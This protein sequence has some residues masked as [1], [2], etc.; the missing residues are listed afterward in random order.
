MACRNAGLFFVLFFRRKR[1]EL[2]ESIT[3]PKPSLKG[4]MQ[5]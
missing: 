3:Y 5:I 2:K 4:G 1:K